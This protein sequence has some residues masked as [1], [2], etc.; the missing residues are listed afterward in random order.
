MKSE[1]EQQAAAECTFRPTIN[2]SSPY[3]GRPASAQ[4]REQ[5]AAPL[6]THVTASAQQ[7][8][9]QADTA[10]MLLPLGHGV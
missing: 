4:V 1:R 3:P 8:C 9:S 6:L 10:S 5:P 2:H 7:R